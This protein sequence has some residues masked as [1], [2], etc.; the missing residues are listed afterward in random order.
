MPV[1]SLTASVMAVCLALSATAIGGDLTRTPVTDPRPLLLA[2]LASPSGEAHGVLTG[3]VA[4]AIRTRFAAT[5]PI[6]IDVST[7]HRF[8][9]VGC[10]R[11][12]VVF[13]QDGVAM[14][15]APVPKK[16]TVEFG[17]NYC[18]DGLPPRQAV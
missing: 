4:D 9:E 15:D 8:A 16:Q 13:W 5:S 14:P 7:E 3:D 1:K 10:S 12:K 2:A 18:R 11:L 6:Y 17:I